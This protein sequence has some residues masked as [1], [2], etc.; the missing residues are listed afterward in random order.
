MIRNAVKL[1]CVSIF[2]ANAFACAQT[3]ESSPDLVSIKDSPGFNHFKNVLELVVEDRATEKRKTQNFYVAR[4]SSD[5][6]ITYMLWQEEK[7]LWILTPGTADKD[8]WL[9]VRY[10]SSG[11]LIDLNKGVVEDEA[12]VGTSTY[13]VPKSWA[14]EK[15]YQAVVHGDLI[16]VDP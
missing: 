6:D 8:S 2:F 15:V 14:Q 13:L 7:K 10:P 16:T 3:Q 9:G 1:L 12:D 5:S 11:Q 4:Y